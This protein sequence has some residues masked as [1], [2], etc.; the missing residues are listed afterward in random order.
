MA[1]E[2]QRPLVGQGS[3]ERREVCKKNGEAWERLIKEEETEADWLVI[4]KYL[5]ILCEDI[6]SQRE[7]I[8]GDWAVAGCTTH[9]RM[10]DIV[11]SVHCHSVL[12][13]P[14]STVEA[15]LEAQC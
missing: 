14:L 4:E 6:K 9:R 2:R 15:I 1:Q 8:G 13:L 5:E 7:R 12:V 3:E 11:R 10:R